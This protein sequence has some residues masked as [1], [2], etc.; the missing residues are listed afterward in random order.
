MNKEQVQSLL[1]KYNL[2]Q[3]TQVAFCRAF[4]EAIPMG[5][6]VRWWSN[7]AICEGQLLAV[8]FKE[9]EP[10]AFVRMGAQGPYVIVEVR[11][12]TL[13]SCLGDTD[14]YTDEEMEKI[15]SPP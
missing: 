12:H 13:L 9:Q 8:A 1:D 4:Q 3:E 11:A 10:T 15:G 5:T 2:I 6:T 14:L 7:R